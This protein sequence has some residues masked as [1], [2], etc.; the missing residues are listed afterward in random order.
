M[1]TVSD[2]T[3]IWLQNF[4]SLVIMIL[5]WQHKDLNNWYEYLTSHHN[6]LAKVCHHTSGTGMRNQTYIIRHSISFKKWIKIHVTTTSKVYVVTIQIFHIIDHVQKSLL[7][8]LLLMYLA[9]QVRYGVWKKKSYK[10]PFF[11]K[12]KELS[13]G[14]ENSLHDFEFL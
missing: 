5:F 14:I 2:K 13:T 6:Y 1:M 12:E 4:D 7:S 8:F 3:T 9:F 10:K 11:P